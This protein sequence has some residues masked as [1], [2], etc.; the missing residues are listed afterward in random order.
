MPGRYSGLAMVRALLI[1]TLFA[2]ILGQSAASTVTS[3]DGNL[4]FE[5]NAPSGQLSYS[6]SFQGKAV[7][8]Q[9]ALRLQLQDQR[10]L[11]NGMT[12]ASQI[13]SQGV[14][15]YKL[16]AGKRS[17]VL[18]R[19]NALSINAEETGPRGRRL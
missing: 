18:V 19:Y 14:D 11:G 1:F 2:S 8:E 12:I 13:P 5:I 15:E 7:V 16:L 10:P 3:P 9:S 17:E 4:R 6:V